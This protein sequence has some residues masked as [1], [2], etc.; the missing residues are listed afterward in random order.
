MKVKLLYISTFLSVVDA[1]LFLRR[2]MSILE[3]FIS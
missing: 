2:A 3:I 1:L